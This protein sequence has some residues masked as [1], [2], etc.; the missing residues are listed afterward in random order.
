MALNIEAGV[1]EDVVSYKLYT[2]C[3]PHSL[4]YPKS[5]CL[6]YKAQGVLNA[7]YAKTRFKPQ[8]T[9]CR[10]RTWAF[11]QYADSRSQWSGQI[12]V[13]LFFKTHQ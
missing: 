5:T 9:S 11:I 6:E 10:E 8:G 12:F 1:A 2:R 3:M 4:N 13:L 7:A